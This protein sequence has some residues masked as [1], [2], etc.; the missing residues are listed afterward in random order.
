MKGLNEGMKNQQMNEQTN[1]VMNEPTLRSCS[2]FRVHKKQVNERD[3]LFMLI[4]VVDMTVAMDGG[5]MRTIHQQLRSGI[6]DPHGT[7]MLP[8]PGFQSAPECLH[9]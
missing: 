4:L 6:M 2:I 7:N 8:F 1:G 9:L 5:L 3:C